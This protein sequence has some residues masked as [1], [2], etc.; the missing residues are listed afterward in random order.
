MGVVG[1]GSQSMMV[2]GFRIGEATVLSPLDYTRLLFATGTAHRE[3]DGVSA[4]AARL[5]P[6]RE[7]LDALMLDLAHQIVRDG[8]GASKFV[9]IEVTGAVSGPSAR[10]IGMVSISSRTRAGSSPRPF[11]MAAT[12]VSM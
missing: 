6:F 2:R 11:A 5:K 8:E 12:A 3:A 10:R 7:A 4:G 1:V 9:E